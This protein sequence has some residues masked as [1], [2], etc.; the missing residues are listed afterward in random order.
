[1]PTTTHGLFHWNE[2]MTWSVEK[3][4]AFYADTLGWSY[5][6]FPME[7]GDYTVCK[8]GDEVAGGIFEMKPGAGFDGIS[9]QWFPYIAVDDIDARV[10]KV[11]G[12][13][14]EVMRPP[15]DVP[16]VGR[17]ATVRD[18]AGAAVGWITPDEQG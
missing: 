11:Q 6:A 4:K 8:A 7:D 1:M 16:G 3:A 15:F 18:K 2:L 5:E 9:D 17:I 12:A 10:A 13:G 14:G